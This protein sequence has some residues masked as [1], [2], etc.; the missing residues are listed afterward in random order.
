MHLLLITLLFIPSLGQATTFSE[1]WQNLWQTP[2]QQGAQYMQQQDYKKASQKFENKSWQAA[3]LYRDKQYKKA[4]EI[5]K[6]SKEIENQYNL[7]NSQAQL[8]QYE[9]AIA[10][11]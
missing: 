7:G 11:Y 4:S 1:F 2:D 5:F 8:H 3:A 9:Q 10:T 6:K